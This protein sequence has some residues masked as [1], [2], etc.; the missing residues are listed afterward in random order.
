MI[1]PIIIMKAIIFSKA[2][3]MFREIL[4]FSILHTHPNNFKKSFFFFFYEFGSVRRDEFISVCVY[5]YIY[6]DVFVCVCVCIYIYIY[7]Y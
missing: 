1:K 3:K 5:I 2:R 6:I 7:I 4:V